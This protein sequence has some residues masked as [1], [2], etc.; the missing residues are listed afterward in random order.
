M[1]PSPHERPTLTVPEVGEL[2]GIGRSAAYAAVASGA[3]PSIR[4]SARRLVVPTAAVRRMLEL[5]PDPPTR[6]ER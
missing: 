5:D 4:V 1:I 6:W 3:I 2:L